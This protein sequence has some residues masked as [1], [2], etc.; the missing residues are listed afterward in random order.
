MAQM[1]CSVC[2]GT[3]LNATGDGS[4]KC[5]F[6]GAVHTKEIVKKMLTEVTGKI[7]VSGKI[8]VDG[9]AALNRLLDNANLLLQKADNAAAQNHAPD[10]VRNVW[11]A[12]ADA[13]AAYRKIVEDYP[14][15]YRAIT[16]LV[17]SD[18]LH[19]MYYYK[20]TCE[21][22]SSSLT[23]QEIRDDVT[24]YKEKLEKNYL[25]AI[26]DPAKKREIEQ[27]CDELTA[28]AL[29]EIAKTKPYFHLWKKL[30]LIWIAILVFLFRGPLSSGI[31]PLNSQS[32]QI[33]FIVVIP[34]II[35]GLWYIKV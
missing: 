35:I 30:A 1:K 7:E 21:S 6:C 20:F 9:S 23:R 8:E 22:S 19:W 2:G 10:S 14:R 34:I 3:E 33:I 31:N 28:K 5:A 26:T 16:G 12:Y 29:K 25:F 15:E 24:Q 27:L 17:K 32:G 4:L 18:I 13:N 11:S